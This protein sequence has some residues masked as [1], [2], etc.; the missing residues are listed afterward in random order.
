MK[1]LFFAICLFSVHFLAA[2]TSIH[3]HNDYEKPKP[4][5]TALENKALN[6]EADVYLE[7]GVLLVAHERK[8]INPERTLK[9]LYIDPIVK[10]FE[11]NKGAISKDKSYKANL[12]IDIKEKGAE[13]IKALVTLIEPHR[14]Y[15]DRK[16]N[17]NAMQ[18]VL[19]GDR[20]AIENWVSYPAYIQFDGRPYEQYD[21]A[22]LDRLAFI[23]D[24]YSKYVI[25]Q[26]PLNL[27]SVKSV[28]ARVHALKKPI[29]FWGAPDN[30]DWWKKFVDLKVDILNTDKVAECR[31]FL[32]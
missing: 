14:K 5:I 31:R 29:R 18:I 15:F 21:R 28:I 32:K 16:I 9:A 12:V 27:D 7:N 6:V 23:S 30:E 19:S 26:E 17:P 4:L 1:N 20:T 11:A 3:S 13:V 10:I 22:T 24:S 2:Q 8:E 25:R